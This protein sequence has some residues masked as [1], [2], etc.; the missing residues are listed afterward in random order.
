MQIAER[1]MTVAELRPGMFVSRLDRDWVGTP[2]LLQGFMIQGDEDL[3]ALR[4]YCMRVTVDVDK[5]ESFVR[6][7]LL[8]PPRQD[9]VMP[10]LEAAKKGV[11]R[12]VVVSLEEELPRAQAATDAAYSL[13]RDIL[14]SLRAGD[15]LDN[16]QIEAAV[17]PVM[18]T[19]L[20]NPD[21]YFWLEALRGRDGYAYTHAMGCCAL[22][23]AFGRH[24]GFPDEALSDL[25]TGGLLMDIGKTQVA[26]ALLGREGPLSAEEAQEMRRHVAYSVALYDQME[27][28]SPIVRQILQSH[29]ERENGSGYPHGQAGD[30]IP[31]FGR[32]AGIVDSYDAMTSK[33]PFQA[34]VSRYEALQ[35][36]YRARGELYQADLLEQFVQCLGAYPVG[37]LVELS[38]GEIG[39]VMAQNQVRRLFPRVMLLTDA[40]KQ[41]LKEF[42]SLDLRDTWAGPDP[43]RISI[44]KGVTPGSYGLDPKELYL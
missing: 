17:Q 31:L 24:L 27:G 44:R 37:S 20:R 41:L 40:D 19:I 11:P 1:E 15:R 22:M 7:V 9:Y 34:P 3:Q 25:A 32:L 42:R 29:H 26:P 33:R 2:W 10:D 8:R 36:M 13:T 16:A 28:A 4:Q 23:A 38:T 5:S 39:M 18:G 43:A 14:D 21:A 35:V 30:A 12:P 6:P